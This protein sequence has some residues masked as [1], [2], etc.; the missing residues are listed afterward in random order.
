MIPKRIPG[1]LIYLANSSKN[2]YSE[3]SLIRREIRK[4]ENL[5]RYENNLE[6]KH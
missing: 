4:E 6:F 5:K 1:Q 2:T 3:N